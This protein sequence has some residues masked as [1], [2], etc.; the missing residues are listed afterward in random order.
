MSKKRVLVGMS[1]GLDSTIAALLLQQ[2]GYEA[3]GIHLKLW[4]DDKAPEMQKNL[5]EN[6]C[7]SVRDLMLARNAAKKMGMPFYVVDLREKFKKAVVDDFLQRFEMGVTPNPCIECNRFVKFG[8]FLDKMRELGADYVATGHY[9]RNTWNEEKNC[10]EFR[11][12]SDDHKDQ[13]YF[14][15]SLTQQKLAHTLFPVGDMNKTKVREIARENGFEE[16]AEKRESQGVCFFPESNHIPFLERHLPPRLFQKGPIILRKTGEKIGEHDG[17]LRFT[18]GQRARIAGCIKPL[19]VLESDLTNNILYVGGDEELFVTE[20]ELQKI[21][22]TM[23]DPGENVQIE[24]R[25]R[26]GG[27]AQ[28]VQLVGNGERRFVRFQEP[29]RAI[30]PG[31]SAVFSEGDLVLGGGIIVGG[32]I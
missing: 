23:A 14:L 17:L 18:V 3:I 6:K 27:K 28:K 29:V 7:C 25:I 4:S 13:S 11:R 15:Y 1:G 20:M 30:T 9:C 8:F 21:T 5:P 12:S 16:F 22:W 26:H 2:Q 24:V 10:W 19:F 32:G 31:Q